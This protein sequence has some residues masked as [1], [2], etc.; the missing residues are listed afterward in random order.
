MRI[1]R[2][3]ILVMFMMLI[4]GCSGPQ[5]REDM[6]HG[7]YDRFRTESM[8]GTTPAENTTKPDMSYDQYTQQRKELLKKD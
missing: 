3:M 5:I 8:R 4:A 7:M 2:A 1:M 6:Y